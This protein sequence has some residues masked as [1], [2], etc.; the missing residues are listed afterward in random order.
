MLDA[1]TF[2][3]QDI[4]DI[5]NEKLIPVKIDAGTDEGM[6]LFNQFQGT[7][8]PMIVFLNKN[9]TGWA[10]RLHP[11]SILLLMVSTNGRDH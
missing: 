5:S 11:I 8:Y 4:I 7:A 9:T 6:T 2:T 3:D 10:G 1:S